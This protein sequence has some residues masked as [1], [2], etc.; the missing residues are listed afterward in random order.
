MRMPHGEPIEW[1]DDETQRYNEG[2]DPAFKDINEGE[3]DYDL[4]NNDNL[5]SSIN[6]SSSQIKYTLPPLILALGVYTGGFWKSFVDTKDKNRKLVEYYT[7]DRISEIT[8]ERF[9]DF[10]EPNLIETN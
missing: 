4:K 1:F 10:P 3:S 9:L 6:S 7:L 5:P 2:Y 8:P